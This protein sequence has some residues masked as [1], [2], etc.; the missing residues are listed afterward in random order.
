VWWWQVTR[1]ALKESSADN[2]LMLAGGVASFSF[3]V[4]P[5]WSVRLSSARQP[6]RGL[7]PSDR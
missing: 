1:R 7:S 5:C 3:L 2:V 4:V 6:R